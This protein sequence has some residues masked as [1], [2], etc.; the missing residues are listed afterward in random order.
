VPPVIATRVWMKGLVDICKES[1]LLSR[2]LLPG[3]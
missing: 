1:P 3:H 2:S